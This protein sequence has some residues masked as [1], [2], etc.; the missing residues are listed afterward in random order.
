MM[1]IEWLTNR[2]LVAHVYCNNQ[3]TDI[4]RLLAQRL[5]DLM[6]ELHETEERLKQWNPHMRKDSKPEV[7]YVGDA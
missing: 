5:D 2:E 6:D 1:A 3:A 7:R 4:E